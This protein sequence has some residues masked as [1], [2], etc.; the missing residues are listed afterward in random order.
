M[1]YGPSTL[2]AL[3]E[4]V[5]AVGGRVPVLFD[6][7]I[8]RGSDIAKAIALGARA[9]LLGRASRWGLGA[10]GPVGVQRLLEILQAELREAMART[11][12]TTLK[13]LDRSA[14]KVDF[15]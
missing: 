6:G 13:A 12:C 5:D 2:E 7:G 15:P 11:G 8:R 9:V 4:V 14:V 3:P 1:D 10:Y